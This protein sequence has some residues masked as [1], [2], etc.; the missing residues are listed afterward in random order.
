MSYMW[1]IASIFVYNV[2]YVYHV[3]IICKGLRLINWE[4]TG[5]T[6]LIHLTTN[7]QGQVKSR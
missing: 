3:V 6:N 7:Y 2:K 1:N 4:F 5:D